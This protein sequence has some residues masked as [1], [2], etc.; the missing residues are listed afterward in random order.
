MRVSEYQPFLTTL[1]AALRPAGFQ[2]LGRSQE[3]KKV[4]ESGDVA[5]IHLNIGLAVLNPSLGVAYGDI[6]KLLP[7]GL[8]AK[9]STMR[10]LSGLFAP[11]KAYS[12]DTEPRELAQDLLVR[13]LAEIDHLLDREAVICDLRATEPGAWPTWSYSHRIRLLPLLLASG[14]KVPEALETARMFGAEAAR[15]D[16]L[17]PNYATFLSAF[18]RRFAV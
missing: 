6:E 4:A 17:L 2:R 12:I 11:A 8:S 3:W 13:G 14:G 18:E 9:A 16:Q 7:D 10:T 15:R 5:W 1:D